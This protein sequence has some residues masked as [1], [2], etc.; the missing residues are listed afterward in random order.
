MFKPNKM[1][2]KKTQSKEPLKS[3]PVKRNFKH[4]GK[5]YKVDRKDKIKLNVKQ[6]EA[7]KKNNLI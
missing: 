6:A 2:V 3:Y 5:E 4:G 7:A 1:E